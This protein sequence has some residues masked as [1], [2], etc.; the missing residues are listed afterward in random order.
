[1]CVC[2]VTMW[3][4]PVVIS[5]SLIPMENYNYKLVVNITSHSEMRV[6]FT[7]IAIINQL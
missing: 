2:T 1:M 6:K 7:N 3:G 4:P 5:W